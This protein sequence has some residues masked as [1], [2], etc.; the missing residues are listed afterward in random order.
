MT[1]FPYSSPLKEYIQGMI[2]Q[3]RSLG[4]KFDSST[5]LL[6]KFDQFCLAYGCT[7]PVLSK[8]LVQI[9]SQKR[10]NEAHATVKHRVGIIRQLALYMTQSGVHVNEIAQLLN[11]GRTAVYQLVREAHFPKP[12]A[13][14]ARCLRWERI[15][16]DAWLLSRKESSN[17]SGACIR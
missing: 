8:E 4:Y 9:W 2:L 1:E 12:Y 6:Y 16:I 5:R 15:E 13:I 7:E 17:Q 3:K 11:L 14:N 10:P